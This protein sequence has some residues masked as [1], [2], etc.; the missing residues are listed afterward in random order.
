MFVVTEMV[1]NELRHAHSDKTWCFPN[2]N[3]ASMLQQLHIPSH[4][5][6]F[7]RQ[8]CCGALWY[9]TVKLVKVLKDRR[10]VINHSGTSINQAFLEK[11]KK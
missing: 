10:D 3:D 11:S 5:G 4:R 1:L 7:A 2:S 9:F 8:R 6:S